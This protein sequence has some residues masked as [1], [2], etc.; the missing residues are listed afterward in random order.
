MQAVLPPRRRRWLWSP[1]VA[2]RD[3][4]TQPIDADGALVDADMGACLTSI[5]QS[6]LPGADQA[7]F[8]AWFEDHSTA[9]AIGPSTAKGTTSDTP[10]DLAKVIEWMA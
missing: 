2:A 9:I 8:L 5:N 1:S 6:R 3:P 4:F 7:P 10:I